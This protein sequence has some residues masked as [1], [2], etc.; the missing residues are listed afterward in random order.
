MAVS[1]PLPKVAKGDSIPA[2][3]ALF[4]KKERRE[5]EFSIC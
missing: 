4:L 3:K 1:N 5:V 2:A